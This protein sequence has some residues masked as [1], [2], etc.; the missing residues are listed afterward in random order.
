M[1]IQQIGAVEAL[2]SSIKTRQDGS[3]TIAFELN[4]ENQEVINSLMNLYLA[5][6]KLIT[7]GIVR[8]EQGGEQHDV[9]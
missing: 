1:E 4:P 3:V 2:I 5:G 6:E 7:L 9:G 8:K